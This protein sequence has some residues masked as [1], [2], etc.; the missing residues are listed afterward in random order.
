MCLRRVFLMKPFI[1]LEADI[2][3][4]CIYLVICS[5]PGV[6]YIGEKCMHGF[7]FSMVIELCISH[8]GWKVT[9]MFYIDLTLRAYFYYH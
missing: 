7:G 5:P 9:I 1:A 6:S 4:V 8:L 3:Y 2:S